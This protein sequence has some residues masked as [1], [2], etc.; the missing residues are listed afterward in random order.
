MT[1]ETVIHDLRY[2]LRQ[3]RG[4]P[5][6][7]LVVVLSLGLGIG[8]NTAIFTLIDAVLLRTLPID[9]P[10]SL[11]VISPRQE[12]G[13]TRG[14]QHDEFRRLRAGQHALTDVAAY[15]TARFN[16]SVDGR[17][18]PAAEGQL[19]SGSYF[20]LLGVRP[21][22]GRLLSIEDDVAPLGHPVA[23]ISYGY[24]NRRFALDPSVIGRTIH[25]SQTPFTIVGVAPREFF[26][27]EVGTAPDIFV[28]LMMQPAVMPATENWLRDSLASAFWLTPIG[29]LG[30]AVSAPQ[31]AAMLAGL[32]VLDPLIKKPSSPGEQP[33][34]I[35]EQLALTAAATGLSALRRQF[36]QPLAILM[37][38][39]GAVLLI[40]CANVATLVLARAAA[41]A[42][43][44]SMRLALGAGRRRLV[45]QLLLEN[46]VL[47]VL[48]GAC[49]LVFARWATA[50]LVAFMSAGRT[51][52]VL[53]L[54]PDATILS[55]TAV[56]A[57]G[58]GI[59]C[60]LA[61]ALRAA[62]VDVIAGIRREARGTIGGRR[63][64]APG[65]A[66]V[67]AQVV[68]CLL[69]LASAGLFVRSLNALDG[70]DQGV[71]RESVLVVRVEPRGSDQR[72]VPGAS[73]RLDRTYRDLL[74]RVRAIPG[75]RSASFAHYAPTARVAYAAP[76]ALPSG[77]RQSVARMMVY[78]QYFSTM[79]LRIAA[80]RDFADSDLDASAPL[81][82]VV[83][84]AFVREIMHGE[85][86]VGRRIVE[87]DNR[88]REIIGVVHDSRYANLREKTPPLV[89]QPFLQ[90]DT[91]RGQM[92][93]HVRTS[94]SSA[95]IVARVR[96]EVQAV[97]PA[98]P[99]FTIH[100]LAAQLEGLLSRER[101]VAT[102]S[103]VFGAL[104]LLL[105][106]VGLYG[107]MAFAVVQRTSELGLR[108][109]LGAARHAVVRLI[110]RDALVLV[111][112]GLIIGLPLAWMA[113]RLAGSR[114]E[115]L[116][117]GVQPAD[118]TAI[119]GAVLLLVA[120]T[121][122][123]AYLPAARAARV[124]PMIALR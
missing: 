76:A 68:V 92:T 62:R 122:I 52:I 49:G 77:D 103:T 94:S 56:V 32:D 42:S 57:I 71:A 105:A 9:D 8:A 95:E 2:A 46:V 120:L 19:V 67:V 112:A 28:P 84:E 61:P 73:Q 5:G 65:K 119:A 29:R 117:Y 97:D 30:A 39:V 27:L 86:A 91:G 78:P 80:G 26:G 116:L 55:F 87:R 101:L 10:A 47:A 99:L 104:A 82:G 75:V 79:E 53:D 13:T 108:L 81:V 121:A 124:D 90:T 93:L 23:V 44:F 88:T 34:V 24:W 51:P 6:F 100:T 40:A 72:G 60:G 98:M 37:W 96:A 110:M 74:E 54:A 66:L 109:A 38:M 7:A 63:W 83:N 12:N 31:A 123:A 89:Y 4:A 36:S 70:Q 15:A 25:L 1:F 43:E 33:Q 114:L 45:Q 41:R 14:L 113:A 20:A 111:G 17:D 35:P 102:L 22:A 69:L 59:L 48:G 64:L 50:M 18:E 118:P 16:V 21:S 115:G 11:Y 58:T 85:N 107:L 106:C 3:L